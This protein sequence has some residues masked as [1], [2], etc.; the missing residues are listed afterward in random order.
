[1]VSTSEIHVRLSVTNMPHPA[2]SVSPQVYWLSSQKRSRNLSWK[3]IYK[4]YILWLL[5][6]HLV[7]LSNINNQQQHSE[8]NIYHLEYQLVV[9]CLDKAERGI[10]KCR[11]SVIPLVCPS[12]IC[13][14]RSKIFICWPIDFKLTHKHYIKNL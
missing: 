13:C 5:F 11:A 12:E 3:K 4:L 14:K 2:G 7:I 1:M 8:W 9:P 6:Y 10:W